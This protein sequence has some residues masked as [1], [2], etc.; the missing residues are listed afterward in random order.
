MGFR[1]LDGRVVVESGQQT[2]VDEGRLIDRVQEIGQRLLAR[3]GIS[4]PRT[5]WPIV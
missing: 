5:R 2:F 3:T 1:S 4:F